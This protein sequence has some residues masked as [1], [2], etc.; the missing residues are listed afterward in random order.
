MR[1]DCAKVGLCVWICLGSASASAGSVEPLYAFENI[2]RSLLEI[3]PVTGFVRT[4]GETGLFA[5]DGVTASHVT[6]EL[7]TIGFELGGPGNALYTL[8][9]ETGA[10][11]LV[12]ALGTPVG[13][14][15]VTVGDDG[16][17]YAFQNTTL[18]GG[19]MGDIY[20]IDTNTGAA[21]LVGNLG[22]GAFFPSAAALDPQTG[23]IWITSHLS[24]ETW[25][26]DPATGQS[27]YLFDLRASASAFAGITFDADG[28]LFGVLQS[29][30][31]ELY[32][33]DRDTL[34]TTL[35]RSLGVRQVSSLTTTIPAPSSAIVVLG[36]GAAGAGRRWRSRVGGGRCRAR[37]S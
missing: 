26:F 16:K 28:R 3:D 9:R 33:I 4:L 23:D 6:G 2:N 12:G 1:K 37:A 20:A 14:D 18:A 22:S 13:L 17:I 31:N 24:G 11:T 7:Y 32:E 25:A 15:A 34:V 30:P 35:I 8:D 10:A 19:A 27:E 21:S 29:D 5:S 36:A